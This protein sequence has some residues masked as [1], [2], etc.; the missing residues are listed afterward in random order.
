MSSSLKHSGPDSNGAVRMDEVVEHCM[1]A[2][3]IGAAAAAAAIGG[4]GIVT[5]SEIVERQHH[6]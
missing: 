1:P 3:F 2:D 6:G 4:G 5:A